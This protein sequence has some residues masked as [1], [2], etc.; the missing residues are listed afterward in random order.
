MKKYLKYLLI[1]PPALLCMVAV[2]FS[3]KQKQPA[4]DTIKAYT[5]FDR[6]A[7]LLTQGWNAELLYSRA[8]TI[9]YEFNTNTYQTYANLQI[10]QRLPLERYAGTRGVLYTYE[11]ENSPLYAELL[12]A[13]GILIG[14]QCYLPEESITLDIHGKEFKI[15]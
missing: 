9:P 4:T 6:S 15:N 3:H 8:V 12:T 10:Q 7:W 1:L 13:D 5:E 11:L 14:A 2:I